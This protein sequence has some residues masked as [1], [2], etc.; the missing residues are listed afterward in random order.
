MS[1]VYES[2]FENKKKKLQ[3]AF[4][5]KKPKTPQLPN[6][7]DSAIFLQFDLQKWFYNHCSNTN[8]IQQV[9]KSQK[10]FSFQI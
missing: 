8:S 6:Q 5:L 10:I 1:L 9:Q 7:K 3:I 2:C 4:A